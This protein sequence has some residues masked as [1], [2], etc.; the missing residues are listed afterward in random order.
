M[1]VPIRSLMP[2]QCPQCGGDRTVAITPQ[3]IECQQ[4]GYILRDHASL[5]P[6]PA[7]PA[8]QPPPARDLTQYIVSYRIRH[9]GGVPGFVDAAYNT[10]LDHLHRQQW[11]DARRALLRCVDYLPDFLDAHLWLARILD[12]PD[13]RREHYKAVL[14]VD[15]RHSEALRELLTMDGQL[16]LTEGFNEYTTP[17][18]VAAEGAVQ[19]TG[20]TR[21]HCPRCHSSGLDSDA[22]SP[23][24]TCRFC[25]YSQL[26]AS[27]R[28]G[29]SSLTQ[30]LLQRRNQPIVWK[31]GARVMACR[32]CGVLRTL[33]AE[34]LADVCPFCDSRQVIE[35]DAL[36]SF[37]QPDALIPFRISPQR[38]EALVYERLNSRAER[39][40]GWFVDNRVERV[41]LVGVYL[42]FWLFDT[43][44]EVRRTVIDR[45]ISGHR[46]GAPQV[47]PHHTETIAD[48]MNDVLVPAVTSPPRLLLERLGRYNVHKRVAYRP[49]YLAQF[50][51]ELYTVD[52][53]AAS[54][55]VHGVVGR[56]MRKKYGALSSQDRQVNVFT[57]VSQMT[58]SLILKPVWVGTVYEKDG[59]TRPALVNGQTGQV[60]LGRANR[61]KG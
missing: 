24:L 25:G 43:I 56:A 4:C 42:P 40:K 50:S 44:V 26:K 5:A 55:D 60:A 45:T 21:L 14:A 31:V 1:A 51:A 58:F 59:D 3:R 15:P 9:P 22:E 33:T 39:F 29:G 23:D 30:A 18:V 2:R 46:Y 12:D 41:A 13:E 17:Q 32:A 36:G 10:A 57:L 6:A 20:T 37:Q 27:A 49:Q 38:A 7:E 11:D 48:M 54:M 8:S 16:Q 19:V 52:F 61:S 53:D 34:R 47:I 28:P 35:T